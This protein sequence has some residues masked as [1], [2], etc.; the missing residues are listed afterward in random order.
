MDAES[1]DNKGKKGIWHNKGK[2]QTEGVVAKG[3]YS[4]SYTPKV[5]EERKF[6]VRLCFSCQSSNHMLK[7]CLSKAKTKPYQVK[8]CMPLV[9]VT[10]ESVPSVAR[11]YHSSGNDADVSPLETDETIMSMVSNNSKL[12]IEEMMSNNVNDVKLCVTPLQYI[13]VCIDNVKCK[14]LCN[15]G[16]QIPMINKRLVGGNAM[17]LGTT[18]QVQGVVGDPVQAELVSLNVSCCPDGNGKFIDVNELTQIVFAATD[19]MTGCDVIL[20]STICDELRTAKP[21]LIMPIPNAN[22]VVVNKSPDVCDSEKPQIDEQPVQS[23]TFS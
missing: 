15:S 2:V 23:D 8:P 7:D 5:T 9:Q 22:R 20:P 19:C 6:V 17:S 12:N 4:T 3:S 1:K 13:D 14:G 16:A 18:V 10:S 11:V 21:C